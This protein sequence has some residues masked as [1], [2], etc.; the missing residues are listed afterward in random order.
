MLTNIADLDLT[1]K[2]YYYMSLTRAFDQKAINLQRTG[3]LGTFPSSF[4]QEGLFVGLGLAMDRNDTLCPYY[5]DQGT[6]IVR[7]AKLSR[8][9]CY[10]GGMEL[11]NDLCLETDDMPFAVPIASQTTYAC[12]LAYAAKIRNQKKVIF[13]TL[14]DGASSKGDFYEAMNMAKLHQL[15][16][17][18][19]INNNGYA[20]S[21]P[22]AEQTANLNL[23]DKGLGFGIPGYDLDGSNIHEVHATIRALRQQC[24]KEGPLLCVAK[25]FRMHDHTTAD[26]AK[27]YLDPN[28]LELGLSADPINHISKLLPASRQKQLTELAKATVADAA[29]EYLST[30]DH[31][32]PFAHVFQNMP[33]CLVAQ[34]QSWELEHEV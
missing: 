5:R 1:A 4:G 27:K 30:I 19:I 14:G 15:A 25:T 2:M 18:F 20:I 24:L 10:W 23:K 3:R 7:G 16:I 29:Q 12:G 28:Y 8:I 6:L 13:C 9:F 33:P 11:G 21:T 34:K 17:I 31:E 32:L 26:D 22:I